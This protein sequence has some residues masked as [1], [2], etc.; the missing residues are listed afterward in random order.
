MARRKMMRLLGNK[1]KMD[2]IKKE[3]EKRTLFDH[4]GSKGKSK[5]LFLKIVV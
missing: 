2:Q 1:K 4:S 5:T 3:T